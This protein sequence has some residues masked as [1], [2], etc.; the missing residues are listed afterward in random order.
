M[1]LSTHSYTPNDKKLNQLFR[2]V[3]DRAVVLDVDLAKTYGLKPAELNKLATKQRNRFPNDFRFKLTACEAE[4]LGLKDNLKNTYVYTEPGIYMLAII[5][6]RPAAIR[7]SLAI[8]R[9]FADTGGFAARIFYSG[10]VYDAFSFFTDLIGRAKHSLTLIDGYVDVN[11][12]DILRHKRS[13]VSV[14]IL[15][16]PS[17]HLSTNEIKKFNSEYPELKVY[18]TADFHDRLLIL[19]DKELFHIGASLKDAGEKS[20]AVTKLAEPREVSLLLDRVKSIINAA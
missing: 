4:A 16:L 20:F 10:Q 18:K 17:S 3:H 19:D 6:D 1:A 12:L 2:Q 9:A 8:V 7:S 5:I 14:R 15:T 11:T 13:N